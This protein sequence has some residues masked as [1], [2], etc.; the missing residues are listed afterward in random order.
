MGDLE[1]DEAG[2]TRQLVGGKDSVCCDAKLG[3]EGNLDV[4][5]VRPAAYAR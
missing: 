4:W 2:V 5:Y 1:F 3:C